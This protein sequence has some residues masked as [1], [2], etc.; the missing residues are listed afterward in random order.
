MKSNVTQVLAHSSHLY[1]SMSL[2]VSRLHPL[3][4]SFN[5]CVYWGEEGQTLL[6]ITQRWSSDSWFWQ[7]VTNLLSVQLTWPKIWKG[8]K[9]LNL[10]HT[11]IM[12]LQ[13]TSN[14]LNLSGHLAPGLS[15]VLHPFLLVP[16]SPFPILF[17]FHPVSALHNPPFFFNQLERFQ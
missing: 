3:G 16:L 4:W 1:S 15:F 13:D 17:L 7:T 12:N 10:S 2:S 8:G 9:D 5:Q 11:D 6:I 14:G